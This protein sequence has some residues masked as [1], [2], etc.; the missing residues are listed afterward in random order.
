MFYPLILNNS[1]LKT[2]Y[3][4][5]VKI[6]VV[7]IFLKQLRHLW[8]TVLLSAFISCQGLKAYF[9]FNY[10]RKSIVDKDRAI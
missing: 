6:D 8:T 1:F 3:I 2:T 9:L 10:F 7:C 5:I 4:V